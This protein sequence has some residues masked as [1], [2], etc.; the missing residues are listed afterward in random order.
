MFHLL[1][2]YNNINIES[3]SFENTFFYIIDNGFIVQ[4]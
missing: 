1:E 4:D 2:N 3:F